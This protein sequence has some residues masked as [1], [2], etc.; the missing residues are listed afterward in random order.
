MRYQNNIGNMLGWTLWIGRL[1]NI[2]MVLSFMCKDGKF[3]TSDF[4]AYF[5]VKVNIQKYPKDLK[6]QKENEK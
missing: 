6:K 5:I 3:P 2:K 4:H 1:L